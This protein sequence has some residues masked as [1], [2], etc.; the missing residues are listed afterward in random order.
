MLLGYIFFLGVKEIMP[1]THLLCKEIYF[2]NEKI[3]FRSTIKTQK[4]EDLTKLQIW[5][6]G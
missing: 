6:R 3:S 2:Y 4:E 1:K 5:E